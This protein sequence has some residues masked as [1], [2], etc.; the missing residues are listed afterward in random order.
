[1]KPILATD[2]LIVHASAISLKIGPWWYGVLISGPSGMGK[3]DLCLRALEAGFH[4]VADDYSQLWLSAKHLYACAPP[5][6]KNLLEVRGL[7]IVV[8]ASRPM[9]RI[10]LVVYGQD[11]VLERL[12]QPE[13]TPVLGHYLPTLRLDLKQASAIAKLRTRLKLMVPERGA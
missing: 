11:E 12:P 8:Q 3:S 4:L 7:G 6:I 10:H 1:M 13:V 5:T 9:T 2:P